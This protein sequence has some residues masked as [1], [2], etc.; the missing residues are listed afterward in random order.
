M[1]Y[2]NRTKILFY[3]L[4]LVNFFIIGMIAA[5]LL[6]AAEDQGLAGGAIIL[7]Y[8]LITSVVTLLFS[9]F[10]SGYIVRNKLKL[11]NK[12][13][14]VVFTLFVIFAFYRYFTMEDRDPYVAPQR[15]TTKSVSPS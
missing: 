2:F 3:F 9:F 5:A 6:S 14:L 8:G 11:I 13:L 1:K 12:F 4:V 7:G 10:I 15:Q